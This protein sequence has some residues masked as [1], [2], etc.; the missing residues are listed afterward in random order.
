MSILYMCLVV[1]TW[2]SR[3][4]LICHSLRGCQVTLVASC[5]DQTLQN[6]TEA[7]HRQQGQPRLWQEQGVGKEIH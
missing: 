4:C 7:N 2:A 1:F 6:G 3:K 5:P